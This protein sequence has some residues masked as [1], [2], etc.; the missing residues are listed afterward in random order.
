MVYDLPAFVTGRALLRRDHI[1]VPPA[2]KSMRAY[3]A[4]ARDIT[5]PS[6]DCRVIVHPDGHSSAG[7]ASMTR[8]SQAFDYY[9]I[10]AFATTVFEGNPA[11][12]VLLDGWPD[13]TTLAAIAAE[14]NLAET[15]FVVPGD[16]VH[17]LRWFTPTCEVELCGHATL[18][19]A[20]VL[21]HCRD[22]FAPPLR[23][24]TRYAGELVVDESDG[25]LWL[26]FPAHP[27]EPAV[28]PPDAAAALGATPQAWLV[29]TNHMAVFD[30]PAV[31]A[32]LT[33]DLAALARQGQQDNRIVI[34]TA[35]A[36]DS[37]QDFVS[38][39]FAP[40]HGVDEDAVTGSAHCMLAPYWRDRLGRNPL[41]GRQLSRR[42]GTVACRVANDRVHLG[43]TAV[44]YAEGRIFFTT[45]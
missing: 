29:G 13:D 24:A 32:G 11:A 40:A 30:D 42:G 33:P 17:E 44:R 12:V 22:G 8:T 37:R 43:G 18:A 7:A 35:P 19:S 1:T 23:F 31:V 45:G 28:A 9:Q 4:V 34:V 16:G 26:D 36:D 10:D 38:R 25:M 15:A 21:L 5:W 41:L 14:H 27:A 39:V 3:P 20:H 2:Y 6:P